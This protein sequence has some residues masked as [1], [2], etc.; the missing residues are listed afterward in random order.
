MF[1]LTDP[2]LDIVACGVTPRSDWLDCRL[3]WFDRGLLEGTRI[4]TD[5]QNEYNIVIPDACIGKH[6][7]V[8]HRNV[9]LYYA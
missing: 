4:L 8:L 3:V 9:R 7:S 6:G 5:G 1:K 2:F